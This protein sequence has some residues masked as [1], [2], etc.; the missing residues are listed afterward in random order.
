MIF[1]LGLKFTRMA[2]LER[3]IM[4]WLAIERE[5]YFKTFAQAAYGDSN[6]FFTV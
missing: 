5:V 4:Y 1:S 2:G 6:G 3:E